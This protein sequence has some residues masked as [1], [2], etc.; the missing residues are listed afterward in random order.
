MNE[1]LQFYLWMIFQTSLW[2]WTRYVEKLIH[3]NSWTYKVWLFKIEVENKGKIEVDWEIRDK[4]EWSG[5][6]FAQLSSLGP[7]QTKQISA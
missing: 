1:E 7:W 6:K 5:L 3:K 2:T 4:A